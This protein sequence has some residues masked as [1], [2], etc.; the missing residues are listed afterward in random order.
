MCHFLSDFFNHWYLHTSSK[1]IQLQITKCWETFSNLRLRHLHLMINRLHLQDVD[2]NMV[3]AIHAIFQMYS[4][5]IR[6][7]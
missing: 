6:E 4:K 1:D 2:D 5:T 3:D 7:E